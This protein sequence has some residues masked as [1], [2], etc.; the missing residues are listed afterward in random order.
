MRS[1]LRLDGVANDA[2]GLRNMLNLVDEDMRQGW[3]N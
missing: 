3:S 1:D 2:V